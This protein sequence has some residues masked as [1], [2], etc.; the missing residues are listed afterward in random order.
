MTFIGELVDILEALIDGSTAL[1]IDLVA[2][3]IAVLGLVRILD[4]VTLFEA[5]ADDL[6]ERVLLVDL[7]LTASSELISALF[8]TSRETLASLTTIPDAS[9]AAVHAA[10]ALVAAHH[11]A[12]LEHGLF[13]V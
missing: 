10:H 3:E 5:A 1:F 6:I 11:D 8:A 12:V 13:S 2:L 4:N 7:I 9:H